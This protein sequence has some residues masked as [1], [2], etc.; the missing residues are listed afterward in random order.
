MATITLDLV[1]FRASFPAYA[2]DTLYPDALIEGKFI[3]ATCIISDEDEGV[4]LSTKQRTRALYLLTAHLLFIDGLISQ[5]QNVVF[6]QGATIDK[7]SVT[8]TPPQADDQFNLW[9]STTPYG[10]EL[11]AIF[12]VATSGGF[13]IGGAPERAAFRRVGGIFQ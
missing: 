13:Y 7:V 8:A 6:V 11:I 2:N 5:G 3:T 1:A 9:L 10:Q 12:T 4:C